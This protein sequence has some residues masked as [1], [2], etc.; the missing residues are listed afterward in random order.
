MRQGRAEFF[1]VSHNADVT[2]F[3]ILD[4]YKVNDAEV[5][6]TEDGQYLVVEPILTSE[7]HSTYRVMMEQLFYSLD[8]LSKSDDPVNYIEQHMWRE[9]ED[10][11]IVDSFSKYFQSL[12]YYLVRDIIGYGILDVLMKDDDIEEI[13]AERFDTKVGVIHRRFTEFNILDTNISF[14]SAISMN[15]YI[16]RL[17]QRSGNSVTA[18]VPIMDA[19]TKEG[20]RIT[21]T[22]GREVSLPGPTIE[23][24]KFTRQPFTISHM[25]GLGTL[26]PIMAAYHWMLFDAKAF[27][28]IVGETGSGKTTLLNALAGL[29]NPRWKV[30]TIEETP[31]L[32]IPHYRWE[33]LVTRTSPMITYSSYDVSV[34]DLIRASLRMRPDIE[35]VGEVRGREAQFLFQSAATGHGGL[36]TIHGASA[37][38]ALNRLASDPINI[39]ASQQMLLWFV[40]HITRIKS[41]DNKFCRKVVSIK[42]VIPGMDSVILRDLFAYDRKA[43]AYNIVSPVDLVK[44]SRKVHEAARILNV[45]PTEDIEKRISLL[46]E[47]REKKSHKEVFST[48]SRYY[49]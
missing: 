43:R 38:A 36:S 15:S 39:K 7:A 46:T 35:I 27:G 41:H 48:I 5:F 14:V 17:V 20:D 23:I 30:L 26:S 13:T 37:E 42:E 3:I 4:S 8:P 40:M 28:L 2:K 1:L 19:M 9:A 6:I 44:N 33:R 18:A 25:L 32:K 34:M 31:E 47:C 10:M 16:Q 45:E 11:A 49:S 21:V 22:Y 24:R 29:S 12:R